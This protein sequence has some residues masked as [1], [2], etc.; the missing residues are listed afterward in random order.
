MI[1]YVAILI[2]FHFKS[3]FEKM[4]SEAKSV[5]GHRGKPTKHFYTIALFKCMETVAFDP[6]G[7]LRVTE[8]TPSNRRF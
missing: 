3:F 8:K 2:S 1:S 5:H 6:K 4:R 7:A